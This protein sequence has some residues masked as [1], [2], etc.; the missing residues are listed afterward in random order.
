MIFVAPKILGGQHDLSWLNMS[1]ASCLADCLTLDCVQHESLGTDCLMMGY[2]PETIR[3]L[4]P[5]L[6]EDK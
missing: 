6:S 2:H 3:L 4:D 5:F 1:G